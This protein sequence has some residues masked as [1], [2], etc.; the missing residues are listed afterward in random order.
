[1]LFME[2]GRLFFENRVLP[3]RRR[4]RKAA[5]TL[6]NVV[7]PEVTLVTLVE[8]CYREISDFGFQIP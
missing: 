6:T 8:I 5:S 3:N 4:Q 2:S 7:L 1:M